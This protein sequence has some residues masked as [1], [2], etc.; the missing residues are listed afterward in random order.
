MCGLETT[1]LRISWSF[2][3]PILISESRES[4]FKQAFQMILLIEV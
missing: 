2:P 1:Y 4:A 3:Q